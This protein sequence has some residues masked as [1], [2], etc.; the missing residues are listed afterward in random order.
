[1]FALWR[2]YQFQ[3]AWREAAYLHIGVLLALTS[4]VYLAGYVWRRRL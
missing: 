1:M 2:A 4:A 3:P